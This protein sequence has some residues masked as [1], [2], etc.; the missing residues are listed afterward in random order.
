[1]TMGTPGA[2]EPMKRGL[3]R[4]LARPLAGGLAAVAACIAVGVLAAV[5]L[6]AAVD[7][8]VVVALYIGG[9]VGVLTALVGRA[10]LTTGVY[11]E[12][13]STDSVRESNRARALNL[14]LGVLLLAIAS[15][16]DT[17]D[18]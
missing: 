17:L 1:M 18:G 16:V 3:L 11:G 2:P 6:D 7:R 9:A 5:V 4:R 14:A 8:S 10:T 15:L 12:F 13:F